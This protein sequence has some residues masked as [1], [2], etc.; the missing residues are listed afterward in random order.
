[1]G[2]GVGFFML[3]PLPLGPWLGTRQQP[4]NHNQTGVNEDKKPTLLLCSAA[5]ANH[6]SYC[7]TAQRQSPVISRAARVEYASSSAGS[8]AGRPSSPF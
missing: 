8:Q 3:M 1:M 7:L 4:S 2:T 6:R 5:T